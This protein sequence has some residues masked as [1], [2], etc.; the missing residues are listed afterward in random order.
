VSRPAEGWRRYVRLWRRPAD[1]EIDDELAFHLQMRTEEYAA[2]GM[3]P[4]RA[5]EEAR[6]RL[7]DIDAARRSCR[8]IAGRRDARL[9]RREWR[10]GLG[11]DFRFA[12]RSLRRTPGLTLAIVLTLALGIGANSAIFSVVNGVLL[13][14]LPFAEP[15]RLVT[16]FDIYL[17]LDLPHSALSEPE[18]LDVERLPAFNAVAGYRPARR[19]LSGAGDPERLPALLVTD[20]FARV[21]GVVP[22]RG[23]FF[24]ADEARPG[25]PA[26]AVLSD[27]LWRRRFGADPAM[28][29]RTVQLDAVPTTV[30]GIMPPGFVFAGAE[31][32]APAI[33]DRAAP[34]PR[35]AH[36]LSA[37]ARLRAGATL[38]EARS[39]ATS[40]SRR[41]VADNADAYSAGGFSLG[42]EPV[43][44]TVV[45]S[46]RPA[47]LTLLGAVAL[48]L[49]VACVNVANLLLV[50]AE[51]RRR[52][53]AVRSALGAGRGRLVRQFLAEGALLALGG[54]GL[55]LALAWAGVPLLLALSP[56]SLPRHED[57]AVDPVVVAVTLALALATGLVFGL[58]P[59]LQATGVHAGSALREGGGR[60]DS[61]RRGWVRRGLVAVE[62]AL[63]VVL[64]AGAGLLLRSFWHLRQIEVGFRPDHVLA[65]DLAL[66]ESRYADTASAVGFYRALEER[67]RALP[68]VAA[69]GGTSHLPLTGA[70]GN[71]D[72][73]IEGRP[74]RPGD[75]A[76][77]P[78]VNM[79]TPGYYRA[80][81]IPMARGRAFDETDGERAPPVV[82]VNET[83]ARALW[84]GEDPVGRRFRVIGDSTEWMTVVGVAGDTRSWGLAA[85]PRAEYTLPVYQLPRA[86]R[87]VRRTLTMVI[88]STGDP[89]T[90]AAP[91]RE[92]VA[93]LDRDL[94]VANLRTLDQVVADSVGDRRLTL[95]LLGLFGGAALLLALVGIYGVTAHGVSQRTR[96]MG[97]RLAL[98]AAPGAVRR[99]VL[100]EG[101]R[102]AGLGLG[103]GLVLA[104]AGGRVLRSQ[105]YGVGSADPATY[106]ALSAVLLLVAAAATWIPARRATRV[107]PAITLRAE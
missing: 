82:V 40:L 80:L 20:N 79:A 86:L 74:Q 45:G 31:L 95:L 8:A 24:A 16:V 70:V 64:V 97:I 49:V 11:Q 84:P 54:G 32:F 91:A 10:L 19:T 42:L 37:V 33:I 53:L 52:E 41:L 57:I 106:V 103:A 18:L 28:V 55:G 99:L 3:S 1:D 12:A 90:V 30:V 75:P 13:R 76:P 61:R 27:G 63:A 21:L 65:L 44:D 87:T 50:R 77:S 5:R 46:A 101:L 9:R 15:D 104:L 7:G 93:G 17:G 34:A 98:G 88:R 92:I 67:L 72:I 89:R 23:R 105:L 38:E 39:Q 36:Y 51:S 2:A 4:E 66:P 94:A 47:L 25:G 71:W 83:M 35:T 22:A 58:A 6:R 14:P 100:G 68:G 59:A 81:R 73:E 78:N 96:E 29:G 85:A 56:T 60:G 26:V 62:V 69:V 43:T 107:D 48:L 102:V